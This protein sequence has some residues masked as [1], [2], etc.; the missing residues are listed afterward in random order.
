MFDLS[1]KVALVTGMAGLLMPKV[2]K[3]LPCCWHGRAIIGADDEAG[4]NTV[5]AIAMLGDGVRSCVYA[6]D[7]SGVEG[8]VKA[9]AA[10]TWPN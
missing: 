5:A 2:T 1:G 3:Q 10:K 8:W 9:C 7:Q 6:T 4:A